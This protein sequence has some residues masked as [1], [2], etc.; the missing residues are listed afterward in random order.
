MTDKDIK[1]KLCGKDTDEESF[2]HGCKEYVCE[3][4]DD[5]GL[6]PP[7]GDHELEHHKK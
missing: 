5:E 3:E 2:C 4:H 6:N 1:C 7:W